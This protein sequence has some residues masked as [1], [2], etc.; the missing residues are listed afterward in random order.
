MDAGRWADAALFVAFA[1][2]LW[3]VHLMF[4]PMYLVFA[5][6]A[7]RRPTLRTAIVFGVLAVA[8]V[9]VAFDALALYREARAH[10]FAPPP[11]LRQLGAAL[12]WPVIVLCAAAAFRWRVRSASWVAVAGWWLC[13]P[14]CLFALSRLTATSVFVPRYFAI[15]LP[16]AALAA[17][18][19]VSLWI[20]ERAWRPLAAAL[21]IAVLAFLGQWRQ[22]WPLHHNSDWRAA[23]REVNQ[24]AGPETPV[25]CPSPFVE[26]APP[27]WRPDYPVSGFLYAHLAVYPIR[28]KVYGLPFTDSAQAEQIAAPP[29][30]G[31]FLIYGWEPQVHFWTDWLRGRPEL[32]GWQ[33]H[34]FGP[35]ADVAVV[36][37]ARVNIIESWRFDF[38]NHN[39]VARTGKEPVAGRRGPL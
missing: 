26:A 8:L 37:F 4:W 18:L 24:L 10:V 36:E 29:R 12:H 7:L 28:G 16:G 27:V 39:V 33:V 13:P 19:A 21:G 35:F 2:M 6:Y 17:T 31:R 25:L 20:P 11:T 15:A 30:A 22:L 1:A 38:G 5:L 14:L 9:P 23:A 3:R 32:A 34:H